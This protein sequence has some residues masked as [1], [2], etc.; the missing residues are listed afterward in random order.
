M[1]CRC[2]FMQCYLCN[3][4]LRND[5][6]GQY[7]EHYCPHVTENGAC[8]Q[9]GKCKLHENAEV[10]DR[11]MVEKERQSGKQQLIQQGF[12]LKRKTVFAEEDKKNLP[13]ATTSQQQIQQ[14]HGGNQ[15]R[16][17]FTAN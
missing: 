17:L 5:F 8:T 9:C 6:R 10:K 14:G 3:Q 4:S 11:A 15:V 2:G 13:L 12:S 7:K 1:T 16:Q